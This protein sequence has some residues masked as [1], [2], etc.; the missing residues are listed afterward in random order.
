MT[1]V[2]PLCPVLYDPV[3]EQQ[4]QDRDIPVA[5]FSGNETHLFLWLC[6]DKSKATSL[7]VT[8]TPPKTSNTTGLPLP[9]TVAP[10][11]GPWVRLPDK[12]ITGHQT[13]V[14]LWLSILGSESFLFGMRSG[15]VPKTAGGVSNGGIGARTRV[16][17]ATRNHC[18][19]AWD[20]SPRHESKGVVRQQKMS[21][22]KSRHPDRSEKYT[23]KERKKEVAMRGHTYLVYTQDSDWD[24]RPSGT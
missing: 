22:L 24:S 20:E 6:H 4:L 21:S 12:A 3:W 7:I 1:I 9:V 5:F 18:C 19:F 17:T 8:V 15:S 16:E 13:S 2:H 11:Q 14:V 23:K 10:I